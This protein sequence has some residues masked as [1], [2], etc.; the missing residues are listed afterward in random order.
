MS[1]WVN[2]FRK[3]G[4]K[5][6]LCYDKLFINFITS[7]IPFII[8]YTRHHDPDLESNGSFPPIL[9]LFKS[10]HNN[11]TR[12]QL[13]SNLFSYLYYFH[14]NPVIPFH[15]PRPKTTYESHF[16]KQL[17]I[18]PKLENQHKIVECLF[19]D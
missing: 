19:T 17:Y 9:I 3:N 15:S 2:E 11:F 8:P 14:L 1:G 5:F 13:I 6:K 7:S 12:T 10:H 16:G 4:M 18:F